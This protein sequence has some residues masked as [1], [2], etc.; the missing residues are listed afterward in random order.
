MSKFD[1]KICVEDSWL[2]AELLAYHEAIRHSRQVARLLDDADENPLLSEL[3]AVCGEVLG[4]QQIVNL[5]SGKLAKQF[6]SEN[7]IGKNPAAG[8]TKEVIGT[9][10]QQ[11]LNLFAL[12]FDECQA[13][14][15][16]LLSPEQ[17]D[18]CFEGRQC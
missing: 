13:N 9:T 15:R 4:V 10:A 1:D 16:E 8:T 14:N 12:M 11:R 2:S 7:S 6:R 3:G 18:K 17:F 5:P